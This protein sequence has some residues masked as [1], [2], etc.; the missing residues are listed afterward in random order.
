MPLHFLCFWRPR[1]VIT[2]LKPLPT[3]IFNNGEMTH[4]LS[5]GLHTSTT[6]MTDYHP[7]ITITE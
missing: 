1:G 5:K 7:L 2:F 3:F 6:Q 4:R